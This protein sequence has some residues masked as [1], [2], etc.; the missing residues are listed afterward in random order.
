MG[1]GSRGNNMMDPADTAWLMMSSVLVL[2]MTLPAL[3]LFYAGLVQ[4]KNI[5]SVLIQCLAIACTISLLWF[6]VGYSEELSGTGPLL[7]EL[8]AVFLLHARRGAVDPG[9]RV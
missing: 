7:G 6:V 9:S 8:N 4:A 2:M 5:L 1:S 3:G